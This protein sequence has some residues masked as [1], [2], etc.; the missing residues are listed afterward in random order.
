MRARG[1]ARAEGPDREAASEGSDGAVGSGCRPRGCRGRRDA[2][3][4]RRARRWVSMETR[5][6]RLSDDGVEQGALE[7]EVHG[8]GVGGGG[9]AGH[10]HAQPVGF[11]GGDEA[12]GVELDGDL[13]SGA[14][15]DPER[16]LSGVAVEAGLSLGAA[17][18]GDRRRLAG[19]R[20]LGGSGRAGRRGR[21]R[22]R[23]S[24]AFAAADRRLGHGGDRA[25]E[26][27]DRGGV[28]VLETVEVAGPVHQAGVGP[29]VRRAL[30]RRAEAGDQ[31]RRHPLPGAPPTT[32]PVDVEAEVVQLGSRLPR[33]LHRAI[34]GRGLER[35]QLHRGRAVELVRSD[36]PGGAPRPSVAVD[37]V[38]ERGGQIAGVVQGLVAGTSRSE[39]EVLARR[40]EV[41]ERHAPFAAG[42]RAARSRGW[43]P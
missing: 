37:V 40:G 6:A 26:G 33:Q 22:E 30:G 23:R 24:A 39:M 1:T 18:L 12:R 20:R 8:A 42:V 38:V 41:H 14:G 10:V 28:D 31:R 16:G 32:S 9:E 43:W 17:V 5:R 36:V 13:V 35:H 29:G 2:G 21:A 4:G 7:G 3:R 11:G 34:A 27:G 15:E 25:V 19:R